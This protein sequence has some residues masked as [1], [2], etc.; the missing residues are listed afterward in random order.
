MGRVEL[1]RARCAQLIGTEGRM[2][3]EQIDMIDCYL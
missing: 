2:T 1:S 3:L